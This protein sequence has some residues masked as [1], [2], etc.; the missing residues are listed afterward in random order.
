M[1]GAYERY[2][3][4]T[5][6]HTVNNYL[7]VDISAFYVDISKDRLYTLGPRVPAAAGRPRPRC[8][9]IAGGIT[10]L[11]API[12]PMT[13]D[14]LWRHLPGADADSVHLADFPAEPESLV[15]ARPH[16]PVGPGCSS[17]RDAVNGELEKL[18]QDKVVGTSLEAAV[19]LTAD[20]GLG[21]LLEAY[22]DD[23][24]TL[25]ITSAVSLRTGAPA[26]D[27]ED[28]A[29]YRDADGCAR[30]EVGRADAAKCPRC[31]RW[32][33]PATPPRI[34]PRRRSATGARTR[35]RTWPRAWRD[36]GRTMPTIE[37]SLTEIQSRLEGAEREWPEQRLTEL[38]EQMGS[39]ELSDWRTDIEILVD[40]FH[41]K[42]RRN[43]LQ[44]YKARIG[45]S[46]EATTQIEEPAI[47]HVNIGPD[48]A[49][50]RDF[51]H[52]LQ[53]LRE[54][55]IF[56]WSTFYRTDWRDTSRISSRRCRTSPPTISG[57]RSLTRSRNTRATS[58]PPATNTPNATDAVTTTPSAGPPTA[59]R[60]SLPCPSSS[61]PR[62][63]PPP[64]IRGPLT[65]FACSVG[66]RDRHPH[67]L[68]VNIVR[69][70]D[71]WRAPA[72]V[73]SFMDALLRFPPSAPRG[74]DHR[75]SRDRVPE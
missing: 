54:H 19:T 59:W 55:H 31:W 7:T 3:L 42:R 24:A 30:I 43:L 17:L 2:E 67:G 33:M 40:K 23:L 63:H 37:V 6:V 44:I 29:V 58:S 48:S 60:V 11:L 64:P 53:E 47:S 25:F 12:L 68:V 13:C 36:G 61:T 1:L 34:R 49:L 69:Q 71:R 26:G 35:S 45:A 27:G 9:R 4:Q 39:A 62:G 70:G 5:V 8:T 75:R 38:M 14:E 73:P 56:Q 57:T 50:V 65:L 15:D 74:T 22:R 28:G 41:K 21:D 20:G 10:R 16:R 18:R 32:V 66:S 52:T 72:P 46:G 51:E